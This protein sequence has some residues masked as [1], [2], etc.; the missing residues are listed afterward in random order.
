MVDDYDGVWDQFDSI[1]GIENL[2][3]IHMNDS[4]HPF[5]SHKD[6]HQNI[7]DGFLGM[8]PFRN[9]MTDSRLSAVPKILETPKGD[10]PIRSDMHNLS[11]LRS[12]R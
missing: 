8:D 12:F 1:L 5:L 7:G 10:D 11:L 4:Q 6:R 9:I 3:L 2:G